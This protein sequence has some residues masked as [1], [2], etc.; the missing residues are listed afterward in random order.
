MNIELLEHC[1]LTVCASSTLVHS[2]PAC[3]GGCG[4]SC[5]QSAW[6]P[7][8]FFLSTTK[9]RSCVA[10]SAFTS[11][12]THRSDPPPWLHAKP[13][14]HNRGVGVNEASV[15]QPASWALRSLQGGGHPAAGVRDSN[16]L[17]AFAA[18]V[19]TASHWRERACQEE[20]RLKRSL[21]RDRPALSQ[22]CAAVSMHGRRHSPIMIVKGSRQ[23]R[24]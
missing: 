8:L 6:P 3:I 18:I 23:R 21:H 11:L 14:V 24:P 10:F 12:R 22:Y 5:G 15:G 4:G 9:S 17:T 1:I 20:P 2:L 7:V 13:S 19:I 16:R